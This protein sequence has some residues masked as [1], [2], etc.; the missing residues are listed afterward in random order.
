MSRDLVFY[1]RYIARS[2]T[3]HR[4]A[5]DKDGPEREREKSKKTG[6]SPR[7]QRSKKHMVVYYSIM[8]HMFATSHLH[9][10]TSVVH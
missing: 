7:N 8:E 9:L 5:F 6:L 2:T 1:E 4:Y 10:D 3:H